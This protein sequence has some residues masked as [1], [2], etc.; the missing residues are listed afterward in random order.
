MT[1]LIAIVSTVLAGVIAYVLARSIAIPVQQTANMLKDIAEGEGDLTR[2]LD[3]LT[4]DE[5]GSLA[6]YFNLFLDKLQGIIGN[7]ATT[8]QTK[9]P[10]P[11]KSWLPGQRRFP[12]RHTRYQSLQL[13]LP[14]S[15]GRK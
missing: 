13:R 5:V 14:G 11:A 10:H 2:R 15:P 4:S 7:I 12:M 6:Q 8:R 3:V 9:L 1:A